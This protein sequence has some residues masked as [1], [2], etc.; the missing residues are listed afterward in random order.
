MKE[1]GKRVNQ[2]NGPEGN[3]REPELPGGS[4]ERSPE[5]GGWVDDAC[6]VITV[7]VTMAI[8]MEQAC[9]PLGGFTRKEFYRHVQYNLV[10]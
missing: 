8:N 10:A 6:P 9:L 2:K 3:S 1:E 7:K 5:V 4:R